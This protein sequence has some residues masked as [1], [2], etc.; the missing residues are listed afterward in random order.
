LC[1]QD[2][3]VQEPY[4]IKQ[5]N[6]RVAG[7]FVISKAKNQKIKIKNQKS[8]IKNQ[9]SKIKNQKSKIKNQKYRLKIKKTARRILSA[10]LLVHP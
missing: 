8:K 2:I 5:K 4:I 10:E 7:V 3:I 1:A 9:K 6:Q